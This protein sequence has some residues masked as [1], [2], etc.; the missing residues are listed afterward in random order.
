MPS[1]K[2]KKVFPLKGDY[3]QAL[4]VSA[5]RYA[6]GR[7]TYM[8]SLTCE[9]LRSHIDD[10]APKTAFIL[11]RDIRQEWCDWYAPEGRMADVSTGKDHPYYVLD[12]APFVALLPLLDKAM[13]PVLDGVERFEGPQP[14]VPYMRWADVPEE[15]RWNG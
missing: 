14:P 3:E 8:P 5:V 11:A 13:R 4:L 6:F 10:V 7:S 2:E 1:E 12:V 15:V 9:V